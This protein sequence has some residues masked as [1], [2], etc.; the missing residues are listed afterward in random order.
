MAIDRLQSPRAA[1]PVAAASAQ[2]TFAP[3]R[4]E[5]SPIAQCRPLDIG[6]I[7]QS[8]RET[9]YRWD[10]ESDRI[11]WATNASAVL[12]VDAA[13]NLATGQALHAHIASEHAGA[14]HEAVTRARA[15][16]EAAGEATAYRF[17]IRFMPRGRRLHDEI[18]LEDQGM[19]FRDAHG[20]VVEAAGL[21]RVIDERREDE[22]RHGALDERDP[23][24]GLLNGARLNEALGSL[25]AEASATGK[26]AAFLMMA[27][28][29]LGAINETFGFSAG[30]HTIAEVGRRI[31]SR[32]RAGDAAGRFSGN[33]LGVIVHDCNLSAMRTVAE[34]LIDAVRSTPI[35]GPECRIVASASVGGV[36]L[37]DS[38]SNTSDAFG[39]A[40]HALHGAQRGGKNTFRA[41]VQG[42][43]LERQR[44][45]N[46]R[47]ADDLVEAVEKQRM[48]LALQPI[49]STR[50]LQPIFYEC[51]LRMDRD[52]GTT[53]SAGALMPIA[54]QLG[55]SR[56]VDR[57][58]LELA[59]A[60]LR[61]DPSIVVSVN[62]SGLT[63]VDHDWILALDRETSGD[64][65]ITSRLIVEITETVA[66][67][68]VDKSIAFV[69]TLKELGCRVAIDD[70]GAGYT[71]FRNLK[72]LGVD[73]VKID[74]SFIAGLAKAPEDR[75]FV[76]KLAELAQHFGV[77]TVA[78]W[79][80]D[81]VTAR[82]LTEV[83]IDYLQGFHFGRPVLCR[84]GFSV[85][86]A[87]EAG[88]A[89]PEVLAAS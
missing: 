53:I 1:A 47:V 25:I 59:L 66:I 20:R 40:L 34:R 74:G 83:G 37:P 58:V 12:G 55:L 85:R 29:N 70:F 18:W 27:I 28:D 4:D 69:D 61:A 21:M 87:V 13:A 46:A 54:E 14:H 7:L 2:Q 84:P 88:T 57:H 72:L 52:D 68:D 23:L 22:R 81:D 8:V 17:Q 63:A 35:E 60:E 26:P 73:M 78:E 51:L 6:A 31:A 49:V 56:L 89:E 19:A 15:S 36:I 86:E 32:L 3:A 30:D 65:Q 77:E 16:S 64:R 62:V 9:A 41:Y 38:A 71:S 42:E 48:R 76:E 44:S 5:T 75:V 67:E 39:H 80:S 50:S 45:R 10:I 43:A 11:V 82:M 79:V 33:K 24:T